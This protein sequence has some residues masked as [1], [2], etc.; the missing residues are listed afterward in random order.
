MPGGIARAGL[1]VPAVR[2][3]EATGLAADVARVGLG[4]QR[5]LPAAAWLDDHGFYCPRLK[6]RL[7]KPECVK[8]Q[9]RRKV[10]LWRD[11]YR[12]TKYDAPDEL[13]CQ[14]GDCELGRTHLVELK[15]GG[16]KRQPRC[17]TRGGVNLTQCRR[18]AVPGR[19]LCAKCLEKGRASMR[20]RRKAMEQQLGGSWVR[21]KAKDG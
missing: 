5:P 21:K 12:L 15:A 20:R 18:R 6:A 16:R 13:Y 8:R 10:I 3:H 2:G 4:V 1:S 14:S 11:G 17:S 7:G 9:Q 19:R